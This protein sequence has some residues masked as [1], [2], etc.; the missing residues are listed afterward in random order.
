[1]FFGIISRNSQLLNDED[2]KNFPLT[3]IEDCY[4]FDLKNKYYNTKLKHN[5][6]LSFGT[7]V[8]IK[9]DLTKNKINIYFDGEKVK[10]NSIDIKDSSLG[11]YPAFSLSS[12][13]EIQVKYG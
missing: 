1:M 9:V 13:K 11:Y 8:S 5:K 2:Y 10:N 4:E 12:G 7:I 6:I 3:E